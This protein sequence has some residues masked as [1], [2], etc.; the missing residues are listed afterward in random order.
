MKDFDFS[1]V[2]V[3]S[4]IFARINCLRI[5]YQLASVNL[6]HFSVEQDSHRK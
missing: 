5:L 3:S 6:V 4:L 2:T 1:N